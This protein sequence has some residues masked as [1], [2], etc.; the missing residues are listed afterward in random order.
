MGMGTDDIGDGDQIVLIS[1][2]NVPMV[3]RAA[4]DDRF[5]IVGPAYID[6]IMNGEAW[7]EQGLVDLEFE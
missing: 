5:Q 7:S 3:V 4:R 2:L 1:G 6:G